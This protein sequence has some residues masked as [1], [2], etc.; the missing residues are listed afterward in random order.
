MEVIKA[1]EN[2]NTNI[3]TLLAG[4]RIG[5]TM[6]AANMGIYWGVN[7]PGCTIYWVSPSDSQAHKV[8]TQLVNVLK[9]TGEVR[10][11]KGKM[12]DT[13][14]IFNNNSKILFRSA[15]SEDSLRGEGVTYLILDEAAFIKESTYNT[16][17]EP[18]LAV[19]GKKTF[20]ITTPKG[21]NWIHKMYLK[22]LP[23]SDD[24]PFYTSFKFS[25]YDSPYV[26]LDL[27]DRKRRELPDKIFQQEY[28]ADFVDSSSVFNNI[29]DL[30]QLSPIDKP[31]EGVRY[32]AG[33]DIGLIT[34]ASVLTVI[35]ESG[36]MVAY[37]RW[38]KIESPDLI[39]EIIKL[40]E[41]WQFEKI[42]IEN[43]NQGLTI[44]QDIKRKIKNVVDF[45]TNTKTK[46]EIINR[47]I[48]LFNMKEMQLIE[49]DYLEEELGSFIFKQTETGGIKFQ[50]DTGAHDDLVMSLAIARFC[51]ETGRLPIKNLLKFY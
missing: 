11:N 6:L 16:I 18:M 31:L 20:I 3:V 23:Q 13:E 25:S 14:I 38:K 30:M 37:Y 39:N 40:N 29:R 1:L 42:M 45:N 27:I 15:K 10:S 49:D 46:P 41:R 19:G 22:G 34:D 4:R 24:Y 32:W 43:N 35:D 28:M 50:A 9:P 44:Y 33:V 51:Y 21:K 36:N 26:N 8:Y 5:K 17:L 12:G 48:H 7:D 47:L 2:K